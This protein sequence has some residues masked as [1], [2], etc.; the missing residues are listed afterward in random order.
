MS[1]A[2]VGAR[3]RWNQRVFTESALVGASQRWP[4]PLQVVLQLCARP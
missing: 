3:E 1:R 2:L 4:A